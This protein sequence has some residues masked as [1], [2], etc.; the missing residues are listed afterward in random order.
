MLSLKE[1]QENNYP[2]DDTA[3]F[4]KLIGDLSLEAQDSVSPLFA[5]DCEMVPVL[6]WNSRK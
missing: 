3:D 1:R 6:S 2:M 5:I 4:V